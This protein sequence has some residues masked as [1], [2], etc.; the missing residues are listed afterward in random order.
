MKRKMVYDYI[1][2]WIIKI[3]IMD[4]L[5]GSTRKPFTRMLHKKFI[6]IIIY[7]SKDWCIMFQVLIVNLS[8]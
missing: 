7:I 1:N 4:I 5:H 3:C 8:I 2:I 6:N